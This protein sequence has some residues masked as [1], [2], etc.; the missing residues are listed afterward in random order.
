[1]KTTAFSIVELLIAVT[2]SA[3][4]MAAALF[5]L[6]AGMRSH[7]RMAAPDSPA[8]AELVFYRA[9]GSDVSSAM[10][11]GAFAGD[12]KSMSFTRLASPDNSTNKLAAARVEWLLHPARGAVRTLTFEDAPKPRTEAFA[13]P[14]GKNLSYRIP[15]E[16][17]RDTWNS[18]TYPAQI[19]LG[20]TVFTV[21]TSDAGTK[22]EL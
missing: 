22:P 21:W 8:L 10:P 17:W 6:A 12:S 13:V 7:A 18:P 9:V 2:V 19:R 1:M 11:F 20:E 5:A 14:S 3:L 4:I 15:P 16:Q